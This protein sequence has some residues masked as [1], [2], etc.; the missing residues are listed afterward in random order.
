MPVN[1]EVLVD[2]NESILPESMSNFQKSSDTRHAFCNLLIS[3][4][5]TKGLKDMENDGL[6]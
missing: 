2:K 3:L 1:P 4:W 5:F 6:K